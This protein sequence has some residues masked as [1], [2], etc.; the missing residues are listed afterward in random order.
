MLS[1][2]VCAVMVLISN[3]VDESMGV[4]EAA[5]LTMYAPNGSR[6]Y[7]DAVSCAR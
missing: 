7:C 3:A 2:D 1:G 6:G 4:D 5:K